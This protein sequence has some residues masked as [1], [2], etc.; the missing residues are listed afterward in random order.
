MFDMFEKDVVATLISPG[1]NQWWESSK[2][3]FSVVSGYLDQRIIDMEGSVV[4]SH[5]DFGGWLNRADEQ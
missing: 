4:P 3:K 2:D 1:A 5:Q